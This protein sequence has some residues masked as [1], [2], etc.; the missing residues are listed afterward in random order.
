V[1]IGLTEKEAIPLP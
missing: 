1:I